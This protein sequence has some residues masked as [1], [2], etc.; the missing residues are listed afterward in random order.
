MRPVHEQTEGLPR[1]IDIL[2][3]LSLWLAYQEGMRFITA[4]GVQAAIDRARPG[5]LPAP[6]GNR[7]AET[8]TDPGGRLTACAA[9]KHGGARPGRMPMRRRPAA[10]VDP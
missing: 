3:L 8:T 1:Q 2:C 4:K 6:A 7:P 10:D 5:K 9:R